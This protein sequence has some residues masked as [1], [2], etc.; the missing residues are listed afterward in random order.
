M[1]Y[2]ILIPTRERLESVGRMVESVLNTISDVKEVELLFAIDDDYLP[3]K[4]ILESLQKSSPVSIKIFE[5]PRSEFLNRD[6]YNWLCQYAT[7]KYIWIGADDIIYQI[8]NWDLII[9]QKVE[10]FLADKPDRIF[11]ATILDN[12]PAPG[13]PPDDKREYPCFPLTNRET[14]DKVGYFMPPQM[15]TWGADRVIYGIYNPINRLLFVDDTI[16]IDHVGYHQ[17]KTTWDGITDRIG[18]IFA[19]YA[20]SNPLHH[21][22]KQRPFMKAESERIN[23]LIKG[24]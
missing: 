9:E 5:R 2:S 19:K 13:N 4:E 21:P 22:D 14:I 24:G 1:K 6:Y 11:C 20:D 17:T 18:K 12:T 7:G 8:Q 16:Y 10:S 15:P 3:T 23:I